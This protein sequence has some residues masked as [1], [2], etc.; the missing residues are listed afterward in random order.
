MPQEMIPDQ[1]DTLSLSHGKCG[2][3]VMPRR[4]AARCREAAVWTEKE[5]LEEGSGK[6][7]PKSSLSIL[8]SDES[9][10]RLLKKNCS[11]ADIIHQSFMHWVAVY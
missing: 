1:G 7:R 8:F 5:E 3:T 4:T 6:K 10:Y 2:G 9:A 11:E